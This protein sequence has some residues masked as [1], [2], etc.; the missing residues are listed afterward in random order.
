MIQNDRQWRRLPEAQREIVIPEVDL[1]S[2]LR[3][4][5]GGFRRQWKLIGGMMLAMALLALAY[6]MTATPEYTARA[7]L[8]VDPR[9][10]N[11]LTPVE[12]QTA[13]IS[14]ALVVD[15]EIK[16]LESR[17]VTTRVAREL[18]LFDQPPEDN[19]SLLRKAIRGV[20]AVLGMGGLP[21]GLDAD[22]TRAATEEA[23]RRDMMEN[24]D[25]SRD[26]GTYAI[27]V[28]YTSKDPVFA[29]RAANVLV[30]QY[31]LAASDSANADTRRIHGWLEQRV[32]VLGQEVKT[33]DAAV[34]NYRQANDLYKMNLGV[35]PSQA[36]LS[37]ANDLLIRLRQDLITAHST[38]EKIR[39]VIASGQV[40][41]LLDGTLGGDI[42]SPA[43]KDF[44]TRY[45][46]LV[47][48]EQ[49]LVSRWGARSDTVARNRAE[50]QRLRDV[51]MQ[52]AGQM[53]ERLDT[54]QAAI[55][56]Q[57]VATEAQVGDLRGLANADAQKSIQLDELQREADAKRS[58]Y[59]SMLG[60]LATAAQRESFQRAP[61]RVIAQAV[62]PDEASSPKITRT[63]ILALFG[64]LV[65]GCGIAFLREVMDNRLLRISDL[66]D[67]LGLRYLGLLPGVRSSYVVKPSGLLVSPQS[68]AVRR[69]L[70]GLVADLQQRRPD[71][72][73][74]I[75]GIASCHRG[76]GRAQTAGWLASEMAAHD[77]RVA[78]ISIAPEHARLFNGQP[79]HYSLTALG[80][81]DPA[82]AASRIAGLAQPGRPAVVSMAEGVNADLLVP[83]QYRALSAILT[84]LRDKVDHVVFVLPTL[85]DASEAEIAANLIDTAVLALRWGQD[86]AP[87]L[88]TTLSGSRVLRPLLM[89]GLFTA[90]SA[91][92]FARYNG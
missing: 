59:Q 27:D 11:S 4:I 76:E 38:Q 45:A 26:G 69:V 49:D 43:M 71:Y 87:E 10:S 16:I 60:E 61:A 36:E 78:L 91:R 80:Q 57:I 23:I 89:G 31:F 41:G 75:A 33:A 81:I 35:L 54:Q 83:G 50:Q 8:V 42:A 2:T 73:A 53:V 3:A 79:G 58:L 85:S 55:R 30:D 28:S 25:I 72:G 70:R 51:M 88:A 82:Q 86:Q 52:E 13:M 32:R 29:A 44:Q 68:D 5:G 40:G 20:K 24:F 15:S 6:V 62:P 92:G 37:N 19:A 48:E 56:R 9:I 1:A 18:G 12:A 34:A 77:A 17:D 47:S 65:L 14:D 39:S 67:G 66:R 46:S 64:G 63:L 90:P 74:L 84:G 22:A 7:A 21:K